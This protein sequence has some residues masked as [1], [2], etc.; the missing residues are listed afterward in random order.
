MSRKISQ[1]GAVI[2]M[3]QKGNYTH[4]RMCHPKERGKLLFLSHLGRK[5][6]TNLLMEIVLNDSRGR[7]DIRRL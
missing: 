5:A 2:G 1:G 3:C 4:I 6:L 7:C